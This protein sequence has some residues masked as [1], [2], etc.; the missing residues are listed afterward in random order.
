[1]VQ[2][3]LPIQNHQPQTARC[4]LLLA[5]RSAAALVKLDMMAVAAGVLVMPK[6]TPQGMAGPALM[7]A[8]AAAGHL[9]LERKV[10]VAF[11]LTLA[12]AAQGQ[13]VALL[14]TQEPHHP[15]AAGPLRMLTL[16]RVLLVELLWRF[17]DGTRL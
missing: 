2:M 4:F 6:T 14:V 3:R 9:T 17:I 16:G 15:A 8:A 10:Q 13:M 12:M 7:A 11:L 1:M 5:E